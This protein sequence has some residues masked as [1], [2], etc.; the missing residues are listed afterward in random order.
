VYL[1]YF[2]YPEMAGIASFEIHAGGSLSQTAALVREELRSKLPRTPV[3]SQVQTLTEQVQHTLIRERLLAALATCF[4]I[5]ALVLAA[6]GLYGLLA[7]MVT[8][9][10]GEIGIRM[11]LGAER[12]AML[13]LV[14]G[15]RCGCSFSESPWA[16]PRHGLPRA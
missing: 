1:Q 9:S 7:Y 10:T 16:S 15:A 12:G 13:W 2:Q 11:A 5:L 14:I 3:Q 8:R 4:G 6:V